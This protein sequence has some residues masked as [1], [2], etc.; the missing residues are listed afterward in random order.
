M[1][2]R[3]F[4]FILSGLT[5]SFN[6]VFA[7]EMTRPARLAGVWYPGAEAALEKSV[8]AQM[9]APLPKLGSRQLLAII[10]PHAGHRYSGSLA[11][12]A[13]ST[14]A[15][16]RPTTIVL[17]GPSHRTYLKKTSV[18]PKGAY[19]SPLGP[20]QVD[21]G[22][23]QTLSKALGADFNQTAHLKE[24][25]LEVQIPFIKKALPQ[26]RLV[27][28]L[29]GPPNLET[30]RKNGELIARAIRGKP[31]IL[32]ASTDLSHFHPEKT[33]QSM[34]NRLA[35]CVRELDPGKIFTL[36][37]QGKTEACGIQALATVIFA[38][39]QLGADQAEILA[40]STSGQATGDHSRVVGY[41]AG[42]LLAG[43]KQASAKEDLPILNA[44]QQKYLLDLARLSLESAVK[45][46]SMP[47]IKAPE[48]VLMEPRGV[49]VT[50]R[51][52]DRLRG[53]I[54]R[55]LSPPPLASGVV[56]MARA[57]AMSDPR[58]RPVQPEELPQ[59]SIEISVLT[60]F[61]PIKPHQVQVGKDGLM[62]SLD[63]RA[64]LLLPQVPGEMG[65]DKHEYLEGLCRK[66]GLPPGSYSHPRARLERFRALV[67]P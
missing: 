59:I 8:S 50:L 23:S 55:I 45:G 33:A 54:G 27:P 16:A 41:L 40:Q 28:I 63:G 25:C 26:A 24:H 65:W 2:S 38:A 22:L 47:R 42:A 51:K 58:F 37:A 32:A 39:K 48:P 36:S 10:T 66:A 21:Q 56:N 61:E 35:Q 19:D 52:K 34:D 3:L 1:W 5:L 31:V 43:P 62:L 57:A 44:S 18:W 53:C 12:L 15:L 67:F 49:F 46:T 30:A 20:V 29:T 4:L 64:G 11:G 7:G 17:L 13:W 14:A 6:P 9:S 60:P